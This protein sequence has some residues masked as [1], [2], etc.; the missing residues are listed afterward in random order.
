M[1]HTQ[2]VS[3]T[4]LIP[5]FHTLIYQSRMYFSYNQINVCLYLSVPYVNHCRAERNFQYF[6]SPNVH[7]SLAVQ[8]YRY[9]IFDEKRL[10]GCTRIHATHPP[11][12]FSFSFSCIPGYI[13]VCRVKHFIFLTIKKKV[14]FCDDMQIF[15]HDVETENSKS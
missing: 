2:T 14:Y 4:S 5:T 3:T 13:L 7:S 8:Y 15:K 1:Y 12:T 11:S 6:F 9:E 10:T